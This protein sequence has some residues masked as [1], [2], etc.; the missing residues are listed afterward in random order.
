MKGKACGWSG[1]AEGLDGVNNLRL[2]PDNMEVLLVGSDSAVQLD[3][4]VLFWKD[5][6]HDHACM[7]YIKA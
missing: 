2:N 4:V 1:K 6:V 7:C 3:G 5:R